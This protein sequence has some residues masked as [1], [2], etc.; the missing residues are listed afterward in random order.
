MTFQLNNTS[1][2]LLHTEN[3]EIGREKTI[4]GHASDDALSEKHYRQ[5]KEKI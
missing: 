4:L 5:E 3:P 1:T 2:L